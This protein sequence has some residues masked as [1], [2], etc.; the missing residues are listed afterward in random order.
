M[1]LLVG[2]LIL[3]L[4]IGAVVWIRLAGPFRAGNHRR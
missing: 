1:K 2:I 3:G 4:V